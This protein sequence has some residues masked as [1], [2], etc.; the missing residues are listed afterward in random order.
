MKETEY[1]YRLA[2]HC[3]GLHFESLPPGVADHVKY[4]FLDF[5]GLAT[6]GLSMESTHKVHG[7]IQKLGGSGVGTII[8]TALKPLPQYAALANAQNFPF[9]EKGKNFG[10]HF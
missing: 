8:G 3:A 9:D 7:M 2:E 5:L 6:K 1:S 10:S 4:L